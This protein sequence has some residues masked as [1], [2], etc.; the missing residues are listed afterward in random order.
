MAAQTA[1]AFILAYE[2]VIRLTAFACALTVLACWETVRP[3]RVRAFAR[4]IR[5]PHNL[6]IAAL[7]T[8]ILRV[9]FPVAAVGAA[10]LAQDRGWGLLNLVDWPAWTKAGAA[11]VALDLALYA[12]HVAFHKIGALWRLHRLHHTDLDIDVTTGARFHPLEILLSMV[13]KIGL[14]VALGAPPAAVVAFEVLLNAASMFNHA[15]VRLSRRADAFLR[16]LIVTPDM[17]RVHHSIL[18]EETNSNFGFN[19]SWWDRLFGTYRAQPKDGHDAM[20]IGLDTFR[21]PASTGTSGIV[22]QLLLR[23][24][25]RRP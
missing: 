1:S 7:N 18:T 9:V 12:Q 20:V 22:A 17:H 4:R 10:A 16:Q 25:V 8:A 6:G 19:L 15:N 21:D 14:V 13:L 11:I 24:S 2:P 23:N 5:W 3:R